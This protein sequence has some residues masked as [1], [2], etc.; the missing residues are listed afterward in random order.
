MGDSEMQ[1]LRMPPTLSSRQ[2]TP[3]HGVRGISRFP[4]SMFVFIFRTLRIQILRRF[5]LFVLR[6][7]GQFNSTTDALAGSAGDI[8]STDAH[9]PV[10][11]SRFAAWLHG[12]E[13][14]TSR[15]YP[16]KAAD[17]ASS[18]ASAG[19]HASNVAS[20]LIVTAHTYRT[21]KMARTS[22]PWPCRRRNR[23]L[24]RVHRKSLRQ[25]L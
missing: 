3:R 6:F 11:F 16:T 12:F 5:Q 19:K 25:T 14:L 22:H 7:S 24:F 18:S 13:Q 15:W 17:L 2:T 20:Y 21:H 4:C 8:Q 1:Q 9:A 10:L 23:L